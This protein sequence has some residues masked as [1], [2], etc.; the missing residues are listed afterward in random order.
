MVVLM[1]RKHGI[2]ILMGGMES[3]YFLKRALHIPT[4]FS[5]QTPLVD[6][7]EVVVPKKK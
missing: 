2:F 7:S 1:F 4:R 5:Q 6:E 3:V